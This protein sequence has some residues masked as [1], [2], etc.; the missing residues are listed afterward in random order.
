MKKFAISK[1]KTDSY[2]LIPLELKDFIDFEVQR[3]YFIDSKKQ[4]AYTGAHSHFVEKE[5]FIVVKGSCVIQIDEGNG[6]CDIKLV[7][8]EC[9][10]IMNNVWHHFEKMSSDCLIT[11]L[12][13]TNYNP[14][15]SDYVEDYDKFKTCL[16]L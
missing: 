11:A 1:F 10:Y 7:E 2:N 14:D 4:D 3:I 8:N 9:I 6:L 15:R 12:S 5:L 16:H 13:S